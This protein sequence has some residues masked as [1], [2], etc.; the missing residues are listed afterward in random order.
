MWVE[1][2]TISPATGLT[3]TA[4]KLDR[5]LKAEHELGK[6]LAAGR[7]ILGWGAVNTAWL[8]HAGREG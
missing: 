1:E 8:V 5:H 2:A 4:M 7:Q 6:T 3:A